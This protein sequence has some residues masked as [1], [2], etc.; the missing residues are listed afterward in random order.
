MGSGASILVQS[1]VCPSLPPCPEQKYKD[2]ES[3]L[4]IEEVDGL[5]L[6]RKFS[7]DME[8]MLRRKVEA[9]Q[10]CPLPGHVFSPVLR[11]SRRVWLVLSPLSETTL[12]WDGLIPA[13]GSVGLASRATLYLWV[14]TNQDSLSRRSCQGWRHSVLPGPAKLGASLVTKSPEH[15]PHQYTHLR[16]PRGSQSTWGP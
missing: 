7:E 2:V 14:H 15:R 12:V 8:N 6:V 11:A 13:R 16:S 9:V 4:K 3:S 10:V 5:E 1:K